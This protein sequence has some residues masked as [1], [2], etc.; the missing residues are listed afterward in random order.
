MVAPVLSE[1]KISINDI[2][3]VYKANFN[4]R[5]LGKRYS[6]SQLRAMLASKD[7]FMTH[8]FDFSVLSEV[9]KM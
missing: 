1:Q 6:T 9:K 2:P 5:L 8:L 3:K 7:W 4:T